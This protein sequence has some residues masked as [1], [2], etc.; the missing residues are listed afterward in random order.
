MIAD[1]DETLRQLLIQRGNLDAGEVDISF[2]APNREWAAGISKP[3]LNL[4]MYDIRENWQLKNPAPW[5]VERQN[6]NTAVKRRPPVKIDVS[7]MVT[8]WANAVDDEHRLLGRALIT[9]LRYPVLPQEVLQG[10]LAGQEVLAFTAQPDGI[11]KTPADYWGAIDNDLKAAFDYRV[12]LTIDL[13]Q[14]TTTGLVLTRRIQV[15]PMGNGAVEEL[16]QIGGRV[17]VKDDP[18]Q[19]VPGAEVRVLDRGLGTVTDG[20]GRFR[21]SGLG[22]GKFTLVVTA[23]GRPEQRKVV[24]VPGGD[25]DVAI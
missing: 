6:N 15:R 14:E 25:Y 23:A 21:L 18:A 3:T 11:I 19:G 5:M 4:Y 7:Y 10:D 16:T 22:A 2:E 24:Q 8:A 9:F 1:L 20:E 12:T 13:E 17:Y